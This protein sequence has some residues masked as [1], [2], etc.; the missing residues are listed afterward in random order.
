MDVK[1]KGPP[2]PDADGNYESPALLALARVWEDYC[3]EIATA[4]NVLG[5]IHELGSFAHYQLGLLEQQIE[6]KVSD[7]DNES[8]ALI[9]EGF[10]VLLEAC[11]TMLLEFSDT[12]PEGV[13]EP[14][15][16]FF[17]Q[18]YDL[19]QEATNQMMLGHNL[20]MEHIEA[21]AEVSCPFCQHTN[22]RESAKC[23]RC[24]RSLPS[25]VG[26]DAGGF[27]DLTE[28]QGLEQ[29]NKPDGSSTR[30]FAMTSH[31][32]EGWKAGAVTADQLQDFLDGLQNSFSQHLEE[33]HQQE[34]LVSK[35]PPEQQNGLREAIKRTQEGLEMS[36]Q[37]VEKMRLAFV[38]ED[39]RHLFF[40]LSDLEEASKVLVE[41]YWAGEKA[42]KA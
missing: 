36:L 38:E 17:S 9:Y 24:G 13:E 41:A 1:P 27:L 5:V 12:L 4:E 33:T 34:L 29:E 39:D 37:S 21:M 18:G 32:L 11:E 23:D 10:E 6:G 40:G 26:D 2:T 8:F 3:E 30:N 42:S 35:A 7:P 20:A 15:E 14:E 31:I 28:R 25:Q 16:G 19:V 22:S